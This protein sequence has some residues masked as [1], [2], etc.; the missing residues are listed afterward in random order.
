MLKLIRRKS[1]AFRNK[2]SSGQ[3][4]ESKA[5]YTSD[6]YYQAPFASTCGPIL[7]ETDVNDE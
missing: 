3:G 1:Q 5:A 2:L 6:A 4:Q 7:E